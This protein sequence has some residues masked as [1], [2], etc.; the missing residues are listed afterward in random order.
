MSDA[1]VYKDRVGAFDL[2]SSCFGLLNCRSV[3]N[4][5]IILKDYI[6][7]RNFDLFAITETWLRPGETADWRLSSNWLSFLSCSKRK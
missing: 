4:K 5:S 1:G 2:K 7:E 3:C 6:V